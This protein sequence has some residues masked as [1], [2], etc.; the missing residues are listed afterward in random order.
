MLTLAYKMKSFSLAYVMS[1]SVRSW[2]IPTNLLRCAKIERT[3]LA[4]LFRPPSEEV[5][6]RTASVLHNLQSFLVAYLKRIL[7]TL[8]EESYNLSKMSPTIA[9]RN[10]GNIEHHVLGPLL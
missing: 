2:L 8:L 4:R 6:L 10:A 3:H 5:L 7:R 9:R 1:G